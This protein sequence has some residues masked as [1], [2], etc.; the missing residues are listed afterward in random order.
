M[1]TFQHHSIDFEKFFAHAFPRPR[2][3]DLQT[4]IEKD[5]GAGFFIQI[6]S[7]S[8]LELSRWPLL[9]ARYRYFSILAALIDPLCDPFVIEHDTTADA[10]FGE[11]LFPKSVDGHQRYAQAVSEFFGGD[12]AALR[13]LGLNV[14]IEIRS[15]TG[16]SQPRFGNFSQLFDGPLYYYDGTL[17]QFCGLLGFFFP[18]S[19]LFHISDLS[20]Q[21]IG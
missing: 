9:D 12:Q 16:N 18:E 11:P 20:Q 21:R 17:N 3:V 7:S 14:V 6:T 13:C 19:R 2:P 10:Y 4:R 15:S 8:S 1:V 5:F